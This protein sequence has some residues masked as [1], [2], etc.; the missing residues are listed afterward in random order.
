M[1]EV[2]VNKTSVSVKE[3]NQVPA[4]VYLYCLTN[5]FTATCNLLGQKASRQLQ[6]C[7]RSK[8]SLCVSGERKVRK[9]KEGRLNTDNTISVLLTLV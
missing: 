2:T 5:P 3:M 4:C 8:L 6:E 7:S 9:I 1:N